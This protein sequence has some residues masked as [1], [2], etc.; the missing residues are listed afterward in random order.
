[1]S[2]YTVEKRRRRL[3]DLDDLLS[4]TITSIE[5]DAGYADTVRWRFRH[6]LVDEAQD[7][8]P[9]QHRLVELL[10][11]DHDDVFLVGD[12]AQAIYGFTGSDPSLLLDVADRFPGVEVIRLPVNH[13]STPQ[14]VDAGR[15]VLE[16]AEVGTTVESARTDGEPPVER[17]HDDEHA[18]AATVA[19]LIAASDPDLVRTGRV[20]VLARTHATLEPTRRALAAAGVAVRRRAD[21]AGSRL[22][23]L[24][25]E[26]YRLRDPD[27][28]RRWIRDQHEAANEP[29]AEPDGDHGDPR[30]EVAPRR[31]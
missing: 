17:R 14:V 30:R 6:L 15:F 12:P 20:A 24:L 23:A 9:L 27:R 26:A 19:S 10:R 3:V 22:A 28:L 1:M 2:E 18:E 25:D 4:L 13:R 5:R 16:S 31:Q 8:N 21:G 7:L 11:G 29:D